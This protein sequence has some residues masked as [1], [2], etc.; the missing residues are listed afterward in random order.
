MD[1]TCPTCNVLLEV[2]EPEEIRLWACL[3]CRGFAI[4]LPLV[5]KGL[6]PETFKIIWQKL[7]SGETQTGRSCPGCKKPLNELEADGQGGAVII[8]VCRT[9]QT[10]APALANAI[11][12]RYRLKLPD[13]RRA[14]IVPRSARGSLDPKPDPD[15]KSVFNEL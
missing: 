5:R 1:F 15:L 11:F 10:T 8:D 14:R 6:G 7:F 4:T 9:C 3:S 2:Q 12:V 13:K